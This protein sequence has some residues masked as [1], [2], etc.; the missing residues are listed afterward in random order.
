MKN[1]NNEQKSVVLYLRASNHSHPNEALYRQRQQLTAYCE[2]NGYNVADEILAV[3]NRQ[4][5]LPMLR[6]AIDC[7]KNTEDKTLM[8]QSSK[9]VVGTFAEL[10]EI[11]GLIEE[12]GVTIK[13]VDGS[14]ENAVQYGMSP[15]ALIA[16]TLATIDEE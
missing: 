1:C 15:E 7:A 2:A 12:S 3:G 8:M 11:T 14:Y 9:I 5:S 4:Q 16:Q 6:K 10:N 13:T